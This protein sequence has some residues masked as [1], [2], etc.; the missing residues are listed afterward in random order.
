[1]RSQIHGQCHG[2]GGPELGRKVFE[3]PKTDGDNKWYGSGGTGTIYLNRF[4]GTRHAILESK[5]LWP[6]E[7]ILKDAFC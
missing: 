5:L 3:G 7:G 6:N 1:M 2:D 4:L